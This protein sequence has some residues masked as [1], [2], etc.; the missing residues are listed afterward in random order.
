MDVPEQEDANG[1][2]AVREREDGGLRCKDGPAV[3]EEAEDVDGVQS[4][5]EGEEQ[6][7]P[8]GDAAGLLVDGSRQGER[9][10]VESSVD[11][12]S[13]PQVLPRV[14]EGVEEL[15]HIDVPCRVPA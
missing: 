12:L 4:F 8:V 1:V 11:L 6:E 7:D 2:P 13:F 14:C 3:V 10:E 5:A 9:G 15:V